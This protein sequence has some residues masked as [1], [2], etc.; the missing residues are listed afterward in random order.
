[1]DKSQLLNQIIGKD[2]SE[3]WYLTGFLAVMMILLIFVISPNVNE[4]LRRMKLLEDVISANE[5]YDEAINNLRELQKLFEQHRSKFALLDEAIPNKLNAYSFAQEVSSIFL[6]F[7]KD[8]PIGFS[9]FDIGKSTAPKAK[10]Q[11][12]EDAAVAAKPGLIK[13]LL[14]YEMSVDVEASYSEIQNMITDLMRQRRIK[15]ITKIVLS[16]DS[17]S[18]QSADMTMS[19]D[20]VGFYSK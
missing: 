1:M 4:Y 12:S 15:Q 20:F 13:G 18:T 10:S 3:K 2:N 5:Q 6:P 7:T 8:G 16:K 9:G 17:V 19:I 11:E 14:T